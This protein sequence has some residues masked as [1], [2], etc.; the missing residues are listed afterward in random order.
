LT[1]EV[2]IIAGANGSGKTTFARSF[3]EKYP[4]A[5]V[6]ADEIAKEINPGD[7]E[8]PGVKVQA[9]KR[10]LRKIQELLTAN[11]N[12]IIEST[13]S[14]RALLGWIK[15]IKEKEYSIR[16]LYIFLENPGVC[17][18]RI[19]E[20]VLKGGHFVPDADVVR[21]FYRSKRNFWNLYKE[22]ADKWH[23]IYNSEQRFIEFAIGKK[24]VYT[25][26]NKK[27]FAKFIKNI[28]KEGNNGSG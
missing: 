2:V 6:N 14:G 25:V 17:I 16:L 4:F 19:R 24:G 18:E 10:F 12:F 8:N 7:I 28:S 11:E 26:N 22:L 5:F 27:L 3:E 9:G 1:K 13:L 15:K 23:L 20:R 21:R